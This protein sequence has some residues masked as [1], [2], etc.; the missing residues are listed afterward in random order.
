MAEVLI[1]GIGGRRNLIAEVARAYGYESLK[2]E[3]FLATEEF[4]LVEC[5]AHIPLL[6]ITVECT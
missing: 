4:M 5:I 1:I 2:E 6:L 3:Q